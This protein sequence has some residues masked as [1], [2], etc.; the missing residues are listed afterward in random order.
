[1]SSD[2]DSVSS[3][4]TGIGRW[5]AVASE[6][7]CSIIIMLSIGNYLGS[8]WWGPQGALWGSLGGLLVGFLFGI[9]SVYV[10]VGYYDRMDQQST[11]KRTWSPPLEEIY[12]EFDFSDRMGISDST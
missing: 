7:P 3:G 4:M 2:T 8:T 9:Y 1:M 12:E 5:L 10:T 11:M 6:L